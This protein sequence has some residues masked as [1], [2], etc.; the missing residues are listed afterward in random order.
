MNAWYDTRLQDVIFAQ[1][2]NDSVKRMISS[3]LAGYAWDTDNPY[4]QEPARLDTLA[5]LCRNN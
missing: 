1:D 5:E 4:V 2:K 3:I